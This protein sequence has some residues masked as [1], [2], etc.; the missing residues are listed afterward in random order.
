MDII[1]I[2][3]NVILHH[4]IGVRLKKYRKL[5]MNENY[6]TYKTGCCLQHLART[7]RFDF[8]KSCGSYAFFRDDFGLLVS[9]K[10]LS[11]FYIS[12]KS[13]Q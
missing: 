2:L 12:A 5:R 1:Y 8:R 7:F 4:I 6:L 10:R 9:P 13:V 11:P 3:R